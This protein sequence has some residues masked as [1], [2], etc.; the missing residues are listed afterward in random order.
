[1]QVIAKTDGGV[2]ISATDAE[3][4]EIL[5]SVTGEAP[6]EIKV[7]QKIPAI[8]Y[9]TTITKIKGLGKN[10]QFTQL[11]ERLAAFNEEFSALTDVVKGAASIEG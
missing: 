9:A 5:R 3:V 7:G 8:D 6:K 10:W 4:G 2:L 1:M 11:T